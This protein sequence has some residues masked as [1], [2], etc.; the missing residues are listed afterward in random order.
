MTISMT[1][2]EN[3]QAKK[4]GMTKLFAAIDEEYH[5]FIIDEAVGRILR[6]EIEK[7]DDDK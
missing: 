6:R 4:E 2:E 3:I 1:R 7:L 5:S